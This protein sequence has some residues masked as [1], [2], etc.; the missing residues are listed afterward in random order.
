MSAPWLGATPKFSGFFAIAFQHENQVSSFFCNPAD[1]QT[2]GTENMT[3][4]VEVI[5]KIQSVS[6][7]NNWGLG[8]KEGEFIMIGNPCLA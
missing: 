4:L 6:V 8:H 5:M 3:S 7:F 1:N 2:N